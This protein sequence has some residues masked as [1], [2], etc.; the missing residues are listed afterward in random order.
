MI[1]AMMKANCILSCFNK[2]R[3]TKSG[4]VLIL[5]YSVVERLHLHYCL[6]FSGSCAIEMSTNWRR[7]QQMVI[8]MT[9]Q[10]GHTRGEVEGTRLVQPGKEIKQI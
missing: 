3:A 10:L 5:H 6:Q 8:K 1:P 4:E 2:Y 7:I 9:A